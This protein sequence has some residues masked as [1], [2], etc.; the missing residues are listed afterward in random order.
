MTVFR[1]L[2]VGPEEQLEF[3]RK[4][5][6]P[7]DGEKICLKCLGKILFKLIERLSAPP[8]LSLQEEFE[9]LLEICEGIAEDPLIVSAH[10]VEDLHSASRQL[11]ARSIDRRKTLP[12]SV[13]STQSLTRWSTRHKSHMGRTFVPA[14]SL[15]M[16][17][18]K[19]EK[20]PRQPCDLNIFVRDQTAIRN[21]LPLSSF[22]CPGHKAW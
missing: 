11:V 3:L 13:F 5:V 6:E 7:R 10:E 17:I 9:I 4:L 14:D 1:I 21:V 16:H 12:V 2:D 15:R 22:H 19:K 18:L 8:A 20:N